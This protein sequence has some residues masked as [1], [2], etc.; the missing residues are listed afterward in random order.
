MRQNYLVTLLI[1]KTEISKVVEKHSE[2]LRAKHGLSRAIPVKGV[3]WV[4]VLHHIELR[5]QS[6]TAVETSEDLEKLVQESA[7]YLSEIIDALKLLDPKHSTIPGLADTVRRDEK[8]HIPLSFAVSLA[9]KAKTKDEYWNAIHSAS[10]K[11]WKEIK[12]AQHFRPPSA[13]SSTPK[14]GA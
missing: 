5:K 12:I 11:Y 6:E 13:D 10:R 4:D 7:G 9:Q 1:P 2:E 3:L 14:T 8:P